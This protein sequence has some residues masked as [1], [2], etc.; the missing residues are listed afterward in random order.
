MAAMP[1]GRRV[2]ATVL[3]A[4][5]GV[6]KRKRRSSGRLE[7]QDG[8]DND[9]DQVGED[10]PVAAAVAL[11]SPHPA[12]QLVVD[13]KRGKRSPAVNVVHAT[14][15]DSRRSS[16]AAGGAQYA[17]TIIGI[18]SQSVKAERSPREPTTPSSCSAERSPRMRASEPRKTTPSFQEDD[19]FQVDF[20]ALAPPRMIEVVKPKEV[21]LPSWRVVKA[22]TRRR[23]STGDGDSSDEDTSDAVFLLRHNRALE[24]AVAEAAA[25]DAA[26]EIAHARP[27]S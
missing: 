21:P 13:S 15:V 6:G 26:A 18:S 17:V 23:A 14:M 5:S 25:K 12:Q 27:K 19:A 20:G 1:G 7:A 9:S 8:D 2:Q 16:A 4:E 24:R 22:G 11:L 10:G 3:S